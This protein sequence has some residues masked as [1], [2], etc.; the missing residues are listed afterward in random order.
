MV[1]LFWQKLYFLKKAILFCI[2]NDQIM[3][4][5]KFFG[6]HA[7]IVIQIKSE[8]DEIF[9]IF[10]SHLSWLVSKRSQLKLLLNLLSPFIY[11]SKFSSEVLT[12]FDLGYFTRRAQ[13]LCYTD[14]LA[15]RKFSSPE[16]LSKF[17][18]GYPAFH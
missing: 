15:F 5:F 11:M 3:K 1:C 12:S 17:V 18:S 10:C 4:S 2:G 6:Y 9:G 8:H 13:L 14:L 7:V 16:R